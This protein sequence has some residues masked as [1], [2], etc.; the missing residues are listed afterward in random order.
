MFKFRP[1]YLSYIKMSHVLMVTD[2]E[3]PPPWI[4]PNSVRIIFKR[5]VKIF[6]LKNIKNKR[7]KKIQFMTI[8]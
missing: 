7:G 5:I 8:D 2:Y 4:D 3:E 1:K 6:K